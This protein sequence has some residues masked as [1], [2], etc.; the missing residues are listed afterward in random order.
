LNIFN[1]SLNTVVI[2][3]S[4]TLLCCGFLN[5][6]TEENFKNT[7]NHLL[8]F[9][10]GSAFVWSMAVFCCSGCFHP[11]QQSQVNSTNTPKKEMMRI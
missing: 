1:Y 8:V 5:H 10:L 6:T 2:L 3:I 11:E 7:F 4:T 9:G